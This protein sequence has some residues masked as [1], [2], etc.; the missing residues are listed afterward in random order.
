MT[1]ILIEHGQKAPDFSLKDQHGEIHKLANYLG[2]KVILSFHPLAFTRICTYQ[3]QDLEKNKQHLDKL[4]TV[5]FGISVDPIPSK[6]AWA[7]QIGVKNVPLLSDFWPHGEVAK[8]YGIFLEKDGF[9]QRAVF[10]L[11]SEGIV[12]WAKIYPMSERPDI[13]I[14]LTQLAR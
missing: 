12:R 1:Q 13:E 6:H 7:K 3:M 5:A 2:R 4:S 14:I 9:S 8:Q 11:D 10:I